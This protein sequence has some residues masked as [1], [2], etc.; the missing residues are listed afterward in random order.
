[1]IRFRTGD[2]GYVNRNKCSCGRTH[3]R[4]YITGRKDDMFIVS[5][6]NIFPSDVEF[7]IRGLS[8]ITGEY[9]IRVSEKNFTA[10]YAVDIEKQQGS[11]ESDEELAARVSA[12]LKTRIGVKPGKVT[13]LAD[14]TLPRATH[15][16]KRLIDERK[17]NFNI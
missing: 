4:I 17:L 8:G 10:Q 13:V 6:V 7:V 2:I 3:T 12:A 11:S 16:A 14:G 1:M 9:I 15:K 5:G